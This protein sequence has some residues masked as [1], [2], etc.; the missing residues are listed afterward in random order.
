[1]VST[2]TKPPIIIICGP[3]ATGKTTSAIK[4]AEQFNGEIISADSM[5]IYRKM[6]IGTAKPTRKELR[7]K[8]HHMIDIVDPDEH[9]DAAKFAQQAR[10][11]IYTLHRKGLVSVVAGGT[12]LYIKAL[13]QGLF[14]A[15]ALDAE[16]RQSIKAETADLESDVLHH[17][18]KK[19][20]PEAAERIHP[21]DR[22]RIIR[23]IE[24]Q[25]ATG[26]RLSEHQRKH[27]FSDSPF[28]LF[29]IGLDMEREALYARIDRRVDAMIESGLE[30]EVAGLLKSG[31]SGNLKSMQSIGY[32]HMTG[33][34]QGN[35]SREEAIRTMKRDTR[36]YAKRQMTWFRSVE[37]IIWIEPDRIE[38]LFPRIKSFLQDK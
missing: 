21:N 22:F 28:R 3:T 1:M 13:S 34:L 23:A 16:T 18:L 19:I 32:R 6:D 15:E 31:Y 9:F 11:I 36:R 27:G 29:N 20:D 25:A 17:R 4:I 2:S 35:L 37:D 30:E 7:C 10:D 12:G 38:A 14:Q 26:V 24:I 8:P 33:Y 5:Q